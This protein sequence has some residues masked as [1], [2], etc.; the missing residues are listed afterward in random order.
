VHYHSSHTP[1]P[2]SL[3]YFAF[4]VGSCTF[5]THSRSR[6]EIWIWTN[7]FSVLGF[8]IIEIKLYF[9]WGIGYF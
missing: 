7:D 4:Q 5:F 2:F 1:Q 9:K 3:L 8:Y 6:I